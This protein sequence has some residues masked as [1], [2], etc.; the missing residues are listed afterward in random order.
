MTTTTRLRFT[1]NDA[2]TQSIVEAGIDAVE[3]S[4]T[5]VTRPGD[6]DGDNDVDLF[7][8]VR[9]AAFWMKSGC[10]LCG[11]ADRAGNDGKVGPADLYMLGQNWLKGK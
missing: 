7:D 9:F 11:G 4:S 3:I 8:Y 10:G 6:M 1:A 5:A 2:T